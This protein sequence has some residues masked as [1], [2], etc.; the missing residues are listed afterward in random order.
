[1]VINRPQSDSNINLVI[2]P[3]LS[4][5]TILLVYAIYLTRHVINLLNIH[6]H[7]K[8]TYELQN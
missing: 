7:G 4:E 5:A 3:R 2:Q 1:M 8:K 6:H